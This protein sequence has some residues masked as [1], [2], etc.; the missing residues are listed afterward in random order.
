LK[1]TGGYHRGAHCV[2]VCSESILTI[3]Q[4]R[5]NV[6]EEACWGSGEKR[7]RED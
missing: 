3:C 1:L 4:K 7:D 2:Q 6:G 5:L